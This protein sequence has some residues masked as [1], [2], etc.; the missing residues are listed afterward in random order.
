MSS[1][2][3]VAED[4]EINREVIEEMLLLIGLE[5]DL[6]GNGQD[7]VEAALS[8][9]Y[10]VVLM[11]YQMPVMDGL[12]AATRIRVEEMRRREGGGPDAR[13]PIIAMTGN[14]LNEDRNRGLVAGM[15]DYL[16][17]PLRLDQL[18]ATVKKWLK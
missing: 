14:V 2:L 3:L 8:G 13:I 15:D 16:T 5:C 12:E 9:R 17:K 7:A 6:V 4:E 18:T 10:A 1:R 11:D